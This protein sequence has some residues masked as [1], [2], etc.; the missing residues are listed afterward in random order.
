M[1]GTFELGPIV[2]IEDVKLYDVDGLALPVLVH[3]M[4]PGDQRLPPLKI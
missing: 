1:W 3:E 4:N 2:S